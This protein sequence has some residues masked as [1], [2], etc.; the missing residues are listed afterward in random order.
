MCVFK[1]GN[2]AVLCGE[3]HISLRDII[4][5]FCNNNMISYTAATMCVSDQYNYYFSVGMV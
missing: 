4:F 2:V 5:I 1:I 3:T